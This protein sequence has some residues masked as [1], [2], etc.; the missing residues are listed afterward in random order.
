MSRTQGKSKFKSS[1]IQFFF[2]RNN[3]IQELYFNVSRKS[4]TLG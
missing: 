1:Q 4:K 3:I 2:W